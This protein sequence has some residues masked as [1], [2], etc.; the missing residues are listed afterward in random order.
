MAVHD[1]SLEFARQMKSEHLS[2]LDADRLISFRIFRVDSAFIEELRS[3]GLDISD[4]DKLV[5]FRIHGVT[6]KWFA[7]CVQRRGV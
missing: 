2:G 5:A 3:A 4:C 1:V 7:F 6:P